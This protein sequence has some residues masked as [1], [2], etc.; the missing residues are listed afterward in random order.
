MELKEDLIDTRLK[1]VN[2]NQQVSA[3]FDEIE[4]IY[5]EMDPI[6]ESLELRKKYNGFINNYSVVRS[7]KKE[8]RKFFF[9]LR[10]KLPEQ[11]SLF[12]VSPV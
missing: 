5:H 11:S 3:L 2:N 9:Y 8:K 12:E 4:E 10:C 7:K 1:W 6:D